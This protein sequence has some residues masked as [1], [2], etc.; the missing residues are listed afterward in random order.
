M[1]NIGKFVLTTVILV[2]LS[3]VVALPVA[4]GLEYILSEMEIQMRFIPTWFGVGLISFGAFLKLIF[5]I[6]IKKQ[7]EENG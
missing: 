3:G 7:V 2:L 1:K 4:A 6:A 5:D